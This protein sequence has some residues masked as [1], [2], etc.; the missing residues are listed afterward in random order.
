M[1]L[2]NYVLSIPQIYEIDIV[3]CI[4]QVK[5]LQLKAAECFLKVI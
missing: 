4:S 5:I 1:I 3:S 2:L